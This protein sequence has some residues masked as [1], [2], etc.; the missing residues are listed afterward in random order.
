MKTIGPEDQNIHYRPRHLIE[1]DAAEFETPSDSKRERQF[2]YHALDALYHFF[3][4]EPNSDCK[5]DHE[6]SEGEDPRLV[7]PEAIAK[8]MADHFIEDSARIVDSCTYKTEVG[9][10]QFRDGASFIGG[11][12]TRGHTPQIRRWCYKHFRDTVYLDATG[13]SEEYAV[14][15][16]QSAFEQLL[17]LAG[18]T[19]EVIDEGICKRWPTNGKAVLNF[20]NAYQTDSIYESDE[21][22]AE[23][24]LAETKWMIEGKFLAE[25][26]IKIPGF[27]QN[28]NK[29][30]IF[31]AMRYILSGEI[32]LNK[33]YRLM[34][35]LGRTNTRLFFVG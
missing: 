33:L 7:H 27:Q 32:N 17:N 24:D 35:K 11:D 30:V 26:L 12:L 5:T 23:G 6:D 10:T 21:V 2:T 29:L 19:K 8:L 34:A 22:Y 28:F 4:P 1:G 14:G 13:Y 25:E 16:E 20:I 18:R 3:V 31:G 15:K 9:F